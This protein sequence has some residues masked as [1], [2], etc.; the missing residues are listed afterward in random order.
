MPQ[1]AH[2][3]ATVIARLWAAEGTTT[4][5]CLR[6]NLAIP[7][8]RSP[9]SARGVPLQSSRWEFLWRHREPVMH[10]GVEV[11][12]Q[13]LGHVRNLA[14]AAHLDDHQR[15]ASHAVVGEVDDLRLDS[16][17]HLADLLPG[18]ALA[19]IGAKR[20]QRKIDFDY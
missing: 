11:E 6:R 12:H 1:T 13:R 16:S 15:A 2:L 10:R 20:L 9:L 4:R 17:E 18:G 19:D 7:R 5:S 8:G 3:I 14:G